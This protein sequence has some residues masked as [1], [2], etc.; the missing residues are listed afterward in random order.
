MNSSDELSDYSSVSDRQIR[1]LT[2]SYASMAQDYIRLKSSEDANERLRIANRVLNE[3][4]PLYRESLP[5][6]MEYSPG[7]IVDVGSL[8]KT[9]LKV[10]NSSN[11]EQGTFEGFDDNPVNF[12]LFDMPRTLDLPSTSRVRNRD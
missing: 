1:D 5:K 4:L 8:E 12:K 10:V 7:Q 2:E 11:L 9:C 3:T 6:D